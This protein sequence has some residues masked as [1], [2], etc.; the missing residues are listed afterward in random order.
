MEE[1]GVAWTRAAQNCV[2]SNR[3][4]RHTTLPKCTRGYAGLTYAGLCRSMQVYAGDFQARLQSR[5]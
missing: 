4:L 1:S 2:I 5:Q 3:R